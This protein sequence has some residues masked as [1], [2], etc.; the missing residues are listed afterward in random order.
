MSIPR[1]LILTTLSRFPSVILSTLSGNA[2]GTK[3]YTEAIIFIIVTAA[4]SGVGLL[5]YNTI[6]KHVMGIFSYLITNH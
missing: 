4:V 2:V 1:Y 5:I 6:L 3:D